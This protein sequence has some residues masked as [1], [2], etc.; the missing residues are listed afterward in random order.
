MK[1]G[2]APYAACPPMI[3]LQLVMAYKADWPRLKWVDEQR[4]SAPALATRIGV[5]GGFL[6]Y[7]ANQALRL[8]ELPSFRIGKPIAQTRHITYNTTPNA[9]CVVIDPSLRI[10]ITCHF[11]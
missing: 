10:I 2:P 3:R 1:D 5:S 8:L 9:D 6:Y 7:V 11:S 4:V